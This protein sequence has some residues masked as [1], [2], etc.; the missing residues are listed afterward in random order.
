MGW[1]GWTLADRYQGSVIL[2]QIGAEPKLVS[3]L[4]GVLNIFFALGCVP[5]YFTIERVG[6]R[7]VL[8]Y[9]AMAMTVLILI[10]TVLVAV[11]PTPSI[12]WAGIGE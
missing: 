3:L 7:S 11:P 6:R 8:M 5:L 4:A 10:F 1:G 12:Q 9:G 2:S